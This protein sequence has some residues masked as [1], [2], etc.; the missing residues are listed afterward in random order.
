MEFARCAVPVLVGTV[1][2]HQER[3]VSPF[4]QEGPVRSDQ[5]VRALPA[6]Q[7]SYVDEDTAFQ[8]EF[9]PARR[10]K[11][12]PSLGIH[13][14]AL[15]VNRLCHRGNP[16]GRESVAFCERF[17]V[18]A[19]NLCAVDGAKHEVLTCPAP[20][21]SL[22]PRVEVGQHT[23]GGS[24]REPPTGEKPRR[25]MASVVLLYEEIGARLRAARPRE[26]AGA[27]QRSICSVCNGQGTA[28]H[29]HR[30]P[31]CGTPRDEC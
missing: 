24:A 1:P 12:T 10:A 7:T 21:R 28:I 22:A 5:M 31:S 20:P 14:Q 19:R 29:A 6:P 30:R 11:P 17:A 23:K 13:G 27:I 26:P 9:L 15:V 3:H 2:K 18:G 25:E 8:S 4:R 16:V